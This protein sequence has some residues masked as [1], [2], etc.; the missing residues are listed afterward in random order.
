M[1][2]T[3]GV[4]AFSQVIDYTFGG[5]NG[6]YK[7]SSDMMGENLVMKYKSIFQFSDHDSM[8]LQTIR[9]ENE[10]EDLI[11]EV[12]KKASKAYND[13]SDGAKLKASLSSDTDDVQ[14]VG[15]AINSP[16][17]TA[18]YTRIMTYKLG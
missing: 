3:E 2:D 15:T 10:S 12:F 4:R 8:R 6:R 7:I 13:A 18:Y 1:L 17:R 16:K 11:K 9:L 14:L 5:S